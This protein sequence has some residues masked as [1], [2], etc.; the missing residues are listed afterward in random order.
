M[1]Q[2]P[3]TLFVWQ[4]AVDPAAR[5]QKLA[6]HMLDDILSRSGTRTIRFVETTVTAD[7]TASRALFNSFA[8]RYQSPVSE[9][10]LFERERHF[11][12]QHNTEYKLRIGPLSKI[13]GEQK[14]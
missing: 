2:Y 3:D 7:N 10:A 1:P 14:S 12:N 6:S 4:V 11:Q 13:Q 5:G 8:R 9:S